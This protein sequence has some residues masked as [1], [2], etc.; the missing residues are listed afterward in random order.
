MSCLV[1]CINRYTCNPLKKPLDYHSLAPYVKLYFGDPN[2]PEISVGNKPSPKFNH[3]AIV[4]S[5]EMGGSNGIGFKVEI[6][7]QEGGAFH[8]FVEKLNKCMARASGEYKMA[9]E[10]GWV[11]TN[12][13]GT[14][15]IISSPKVVTI[16]IHLEPL[17]SN[18]IAKFIIE[19]YD[20]MQHV[21]TSRHDEVE[22]S[23]DNRMPL[24]Q[25]IIALGQ[26][27]EPKFNVKFVRIEKD[28]SES[29]IVWREGGIM[30]PKSVWECDG[31][32]KMATI[33]KWKEPFVTDRDKGTT[34]VWESRETGYPTMA[35]VEDVSLGC[36]ES[37]PACN[38]VLG[39]YIVNG[40]SC[41]CVISF[42]PKINY[43]P[44]FASLSQGGNSGGGITGQ[45][46]KK[47]KD[48]KTQSPE[49]GLLQSIPVTRAAFD[50]HGKKAVPEMAFAQDKNEKAAAIH[51]PQLQPVTA[52]MI[53][54][55]DPSPNYV[56]PI[57]MI[58][59]YVSIIYINP[60][61]LQDTGS[62]GCGDW[63]ASPGCNEILSNKRWMIKGASHSIK[64]GSYT[65]T[66]SLFL[67]AP[68]LNIEGGA[69]F[70]GPGSEG[71]TPI[72]AC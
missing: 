34:I 44:P 72:N 37:N 12:C 26:N 65:T 55:G 50:V 57:L 14:N 46:V 71:Y 62:E 68:G 64:E 9:A 2:N 39:T 17:I 4:K 13:D 66:L 51:T 25:A 45:T 8:L 20:L 18:G 63:L 31:Q 40:G 15:G 52:E 30:G 16:P 56:H 42:V 28:G 5:F 60:F 3:N 58:G 47:E 67:D 32:N 1:G 54:Q 22:G 53:I 35:I 24:R 36:N 10:W 38:G 21:F 69:P 33:Q 43:I 59:K 48:C 27:A 70:G 29:E 23:D 49:T 61:N 6:V 19:G 41:S 7:D 11:F